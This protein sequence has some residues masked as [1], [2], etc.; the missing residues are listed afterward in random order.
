MRSRAQLFIIEVVVAVTVLIL[1]LS[2]LFSIQNNQSPTQ[3]VDIL[4]GQV[5]NVLDALKESHD[6]YNYFDAAK[7]QYLQGSSLSDTVDTA[8]TVIRAF[9]NTL[10][11]TAS[12]TINLYYQISGNFT[13]IDRLNVVSIPS[14]VQLTS[15][16]DISMGHYS[17]GNALVTDTYRV[18]V[19]AW[20]E[21]G[22]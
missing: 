5:I 2:G 18:Q 3:S 17:T 4:E 16:E 13:P 21:V 15:V 22:Q 7:A 9:E 19:L 1:L 8:M 6:L 14:N 10:P 20:Y 11:A 12:F